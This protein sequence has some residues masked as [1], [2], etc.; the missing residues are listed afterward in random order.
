MNTGIICGQT[1][2]SDGIYS[3]SKRAFSKNKGKD[4]S[5]D[6]NQKQNIGN[7]SHLSCNGSEAVQ[8]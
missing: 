3:S 7:L 5:Q 4:H 6:H 8:I 2:C 1:V